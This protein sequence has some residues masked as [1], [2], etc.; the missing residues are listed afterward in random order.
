MYVRACKSP[1]RLLSRVCAADVRQ[2]RYSMQ[3][4]LIAIL[5][6]RTV[7]RDNC[8]PKP[9]EVGRAGRRVLTSLGTGRTD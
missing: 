5:P 7:I 9:T 4:K 1:V 3:I 6:V 8:L 2:S